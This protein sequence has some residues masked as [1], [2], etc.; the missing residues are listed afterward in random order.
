MQLKN[1]KRAICNNF[2]IFYI[3]YKYYSYFQNKVEKIWI[4]KECIIHKFLYELKP[5]TKL[6][7]LFSKKV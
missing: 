5:S 2:N 1:G 3:K 4:D 7:Q 6:L